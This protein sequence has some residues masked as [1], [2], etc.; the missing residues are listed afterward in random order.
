[1]AT[2]FRFQLWIPAI[3]CSRGFVW[4]FRMFNQAII[5][6][7]KLLNL[8]FSHHYSTLIILAKINGKVQQIIGQ[9]FYNSTRVTRVKRSVG[10]NWPREDK[11]TSYMFISFQTLE[12]QMNDDS[13]VSKDV[14]TSWFRLSHQE[15]HLERRLNDREIRYILIDHIPF[16]AARK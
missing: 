6:F 8:W 11:K 16:K 12:Q 15:G 10:W 9:K 14:R 4:V 5:F 13:P 7:L 1:M 3:C 2:V